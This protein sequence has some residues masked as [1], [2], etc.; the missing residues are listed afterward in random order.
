MADVLVEK[1]KRA[2]SVQPFAI[3]A[4]HPRNADLMI[5]SI[6]GCRL[7]GALSASK[8]TR[9]SKTGEEGLPKDQAISMGS[10]PPI[11][12][13]QLH[14][15]PSALTYQILDPLCENEALCERIRRALSDTRPM[16][17]NSK[18]QGVPPQKGKLD[19]HRM[20]TLCREL[21][22]I[23][24]AREAKLIKGVM[25]TLDDIDDLEGYYLLNPGAIIQNLQPRYEKDFPAWVDNLGR[26]GG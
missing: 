5:Q 7:R 8:T 26:T 10:L 16:R 12:G 22:R 23:V 1:P 20:K 25:P 19:S 6:P 24:E 21:L 11:P 17:S 15:N 18:L 13:M 4:D 14:V 9:D 2:V 3:E